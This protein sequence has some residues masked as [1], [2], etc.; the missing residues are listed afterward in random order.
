M[1]LGKR[2]REGARQ[3]EREGETEGGRERDQAGQ[4][5]WYNND[6][7]KKGISLLWSHSHDHSNNLFFLKFFTINSTVTITTANS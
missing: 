6:E 5:V 3:G 4:P 2:Q 7:G 1:R